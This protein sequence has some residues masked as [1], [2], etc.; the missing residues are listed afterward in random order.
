[1][2]IDTNLLG[3]KLNRYRE[4]FKLSF[5]DISIA[6]GIEKSRL[7]DF[8]IGVATPTGDEILIIA[9]FYKCDYMFFISNE[10]LAPFEETDKLFRRHSNDFSVIDRWSVQEIL[11]LAECDFYLD[12]VLDKK[13]AFDFS[14]EKRGSYYK[15]HAFEAAGILR[16]KLGYSQ[17]E[18]PMDVFQDFHKIGIRVFRR[19][20]RN[21][22]ISG[23]YIR[24]PKAGKCI[25][26]NYS[27][28]VYRQRFSAAHE[29]AH[30]IFDYEEDVSVSFA[31]WNRSD[32]KEIRANTFASNYLMPSEFLARIP[33]VS[34]WNTK[35]AIDWANRIKV[36]TTA[37]AFALRS[38]NLIDDRMEKVI[39]SVKVPS[40]DKRDP[41]L[42]GN[43][44]PKF[45]ERKRK[46]LEKGLSTNYV[47]KCISA[48]KGG[49]I[50]AKRM[51]EMF[52]SIENELR[53][54]LDLFTVDIDYGD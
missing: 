10:K 6:T 7:I 28:D 17:N 38:H 35:K 12:Q 54:L 15:G 27:E 18:I 26:I 16:D 53:D 46:L 36:S 50:T 9:D 13:P 34:S 44:P 48:Y 20:L 3:D 14:Y 29:A 8:E 51:A 42:G 30:A 40:E 45:L 39:K 41:E 22:N 32:L 19:A 11:Y 2:A 21:S 1:L 43:Q 4:Q 25:L 37:L 24:H 23:L 33:Q 31:N 47:S 49:H 52:L 5:N